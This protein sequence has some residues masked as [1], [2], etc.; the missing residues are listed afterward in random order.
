VVVVVVVVAGHAHTLARA[1]G[2][3]HSSIDGI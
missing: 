2:L 1:A 3:S